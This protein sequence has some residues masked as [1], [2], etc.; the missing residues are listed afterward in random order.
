MCIN[1]DIEE[2]RAINRAANIII[3]AHGRKRLSE[4]GIHLKDVMD[5]IEHGEIIEQYPKDYPFPSCLILGKS[6]ADRY[7]HAVV[8]ANREY[9]YLITAY[10]PNSDEWEPDMKTRKEH[11]K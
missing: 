10:E 1:L 9:L 6:V 8:S 11:Q 4:R 2:L 7:L 3:T 5:I